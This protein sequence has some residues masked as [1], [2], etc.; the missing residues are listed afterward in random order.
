MTSSTDLDRGRPG[1]VT[2]GHISRESC[3][4]TARYRQVFPVN[5]QCN[6]WCRPAPESEGSAFG[7]TGGCKTRIVTVVGTKLPVVGDKLKCYL[8]GGR[9]LRRKVHE[10]NR[11]HRSISPAALY[12]HPYDAFTKRLLLPRRTIIFS[13]LA[14]TSTSRPLLASHHWHWVQMRFFSTATFSRRLFQRTVL[15]L[16]SPAFQGYY[17]MSRL[18]LSSVFGSP[19]RDTTRYTWAIGFPGNHCRTPDSAFPEF[20]A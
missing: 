2:V 19:Y 6:G 13:S 9:W 15:V 11:P 7:L 18:Y 10:H 4:T 17:M 16:V 14:H 5:S 8:D 12:A 1:R 20:P 3:S